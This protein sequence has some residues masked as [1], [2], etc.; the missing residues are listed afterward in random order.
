MDAIF[1]GLCDGYSSLDIMCRSPG[2]IQ[3]SY[4]IKVT[5]T[6]LALLLAC[7]HPQLSQVYVQGHIIKVWKLMCRLALIVR[8]LEFFYS[9]L[10]VDVC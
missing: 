7:G 8:A 6:A 4:Q 9:V 3:G 1:K 5:T 2:E 10:H